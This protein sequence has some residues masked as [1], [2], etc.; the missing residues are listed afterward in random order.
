MSSII[1]R[2]SID[3]GQSFPAPLLS[4]YEAAVALKKCQWQ[5]EGYPMDFYANDSLGQWTPNHKPPGKYLRSILQNLMK[6]FSS[7]PF[8]RDFTDIDMLD[9]H[10][11]RYAFTLLARCFKGP[12]ISTYSFISSIALCITLSNDLICF[13]FRMWRLWVW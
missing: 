2:L 1:S 8:I 4:P 5:E 7:N 6:V 10:E 11:S 13:L 12:Y 3:W 9:T